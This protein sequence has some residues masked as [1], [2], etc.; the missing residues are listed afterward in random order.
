MRRVHYI[1]P[2]QVWRTTSPGTPAALSRLGL[3]VA[4]NA[5]DVCASLLTVEVLHSATVPDSM[6]DLCEL[7]GPSWLAL[8]GHERQTAR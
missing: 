4:A 2:S 8:T 1:A 6:C 3:L 7:D 5:C